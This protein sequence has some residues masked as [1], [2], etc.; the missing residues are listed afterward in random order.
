[1]AGPGG[2]Q[3][4]RRRCDLPGARRGPSLPQHDAGPA[5]ADPVQ[6]R[7]PREDDDRAPH[8]RAARRQ[9]RPRCRR[10]AARGHAQDG[11]VEQGLRALPL[12]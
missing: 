5:L 10:E 11:R 9:Q 8:E 1:E 4:P 12:V 3:P 7:P 2:P 6:P